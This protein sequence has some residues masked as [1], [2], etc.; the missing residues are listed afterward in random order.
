MEYKHLTD[1]SQIKKILCHLIIIDQPEND[2]DNQTF[3]DDVIKVLKNLKYDRRSS[4]PVDT[5]TGLQCAQNIRQTS[6]KTKAD[7]PGYNYV[8]VA[9]AGGHIPY[10]GVMHYSF[11]FTILSFT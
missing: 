6:P 10:G 4:R 9:L 1:G 3:Y 7:Y 2:L 5:N 8:R 11:G